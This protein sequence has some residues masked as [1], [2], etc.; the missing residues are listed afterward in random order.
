MAAWQVKGG[1]RT[2]EEYGDKGTKQTNEREV[3]HRP[4]TI[5]YHQL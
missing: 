3:L 1:N 5:M 2:G 4:M